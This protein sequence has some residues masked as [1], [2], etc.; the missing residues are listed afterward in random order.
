[1]PELVPVDHDPF[2]QKMVPVDHDPFAAE[3]AVAGQTMGVIGGLFEGAIKGVEDMIA[4]PSRY[5]QPN[6]Y[7]PGSEEESWYEDQREKLLTDWAPSTALNLTLGAGG[8]PAEANALRTGIGVSSKGPHLESLPRFER[9]EATGM[10]PE[11]N[12]SNTG[13]YRGGDKKLRYW[14]SDEGSAL[15]LDSKALETRPYEYNDRLKKVQVQ[16]LVWE[17]PVPGKGKNPGKPGGYRETTLGDMWNHPDLY[18]AYPW[19]RDIKVEHSTSGNSYSY[20]DQTIRI[21]DAVSDDFQSTLHHEAIHAVQHHE[22]FSPGGDPDEFLP[23]GFNK[24][25]DKL[26]EAHSLLDGDIKA[27]TGW[28]PASARLVVK[29]NP[30]K[31]N[32][33]QRMVL[34]KMRESGVVDKIERLK[35][36][37]ADVQAKREEAFERYQH[38]HGESEA[39]DAPYI[40]RYGAGAVKPGQLPLH[41]NPAVRDSKRAIEV[42]PALHKKPPRMVPVDHNPFKGT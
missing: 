42:L 17:S 13:W 37:E 27:A 20:H 18:E 4:G 3:K 2:T 19:L 36:M 22:G 9:Y 39:R 41:V 29:M 25:D 5:M 30:E 7:K 12:Y 26:A 8:T 32:A 10:S 11:R 35:K 24:I 1:M 31:M 33:E 21:E 23:K 16:N 34:H 28:D 14:L 15:K 38:L 6:P 40:K